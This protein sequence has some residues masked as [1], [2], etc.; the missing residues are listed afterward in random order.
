MKLHSAKLTGYTMPVLE[1]VN[2]PLQLLI[3]HARVSSTANQFKHET[4]ERLFKSLIR[5]KEWSPLE[6]V[7]LNF[8]VYTTRDV[9]QQ[10]IRHKS[11]HFQEMSQRYKDVSE[12]EC[13]VRIARLKHDTDRQKSVDVCL[14][15]PRVA[16]WFEKQ[17]KAYEIAKEAYEWALHQGIAKEVARS[18]LPLGITTKLYVAGT[19]RDFY[20]Y[21][22]VRCDEKTQKEH[23]QVAMSIR[24]HIYDLFPIL[25]EVDNER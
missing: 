14:S 18:V 4:G 16:I 11:L 9:S 5:R 7:S 8:E 17:R 12:Q 3:H 21:C 15:D 1:G 19:L 22:C 25:A 24:Q 20:H 23:R 10:M 13:E 2:T 6:Q